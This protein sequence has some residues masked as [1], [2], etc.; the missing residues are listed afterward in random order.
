MDVMNERVTSCGRDGMM[1]VEFGASV[2]K[3]LLD[4][5]TR[6]GWPAAAVSDVCATVD[7]NPTRRFH[8]RL[9]GTDFRAVGGRVFHANTPIVLSA[10]FEIEDSN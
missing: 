2:Q 1:A 7:E 9:E 6:G 10:V 5:V 8:G 4:A 3:A